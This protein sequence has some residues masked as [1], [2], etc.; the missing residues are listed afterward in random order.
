MPTDD[1]LGAFLEGDDTAAGDLDAARIEHL[2]T[3]LGDEAVWVEPPSGLEDRVVAD[4][5]TEMTTAGFD[6]DDGHVVSLNDGRRRRNVVIGVIGAVAAAIVLFFAYGL[7]DDG[8]YVVDMTG[9]DLA[10]GATGVVTVEST[11]SG[12]AFE[13]DIEGLAPAPEGYYYQAWVEGDLGT[14][15][16]GTFH[17]REDASDVI[18]WSGVGVSD[19]PVLT[20]TLQAEGAGPAPSGEV[21][22]TADLSRDH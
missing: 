18:L 13:F 19:Y 2:R 4:I 22:M 17:A 3:V 1:Q 6:G 7:L 5:A 15:T 14:V 16:I 9:T 8:G 12:Y 11:G 21:L 20:V 10:Q